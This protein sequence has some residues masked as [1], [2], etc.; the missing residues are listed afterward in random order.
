MF[1]HYFGSVSRVNYSVKKTTILEKIL[2]FLRP[3]QL[4]YR[5]INLYISTCIGLMKNKFTFSPKYGKHQ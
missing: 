5:Y 4:T 3:I 2:S 1:C